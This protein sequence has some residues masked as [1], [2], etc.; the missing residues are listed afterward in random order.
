MF[1]KTGWQTLD[2]ILQEGL[3]AILNIN[4]SDDE[5]IRA[6]LPVMNG[7]LRI[8]SATM[9]TLSAILASAIC[10][11]EETSFHKSA[12]HHQAQNSRLVW[13]IGN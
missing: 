10:T 3:L 11:L 9:L 12:R 7:V 6:L 4:L 13:R 5:W 1:K 8:R 2:N